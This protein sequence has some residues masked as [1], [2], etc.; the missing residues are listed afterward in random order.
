MPRHGR[1]VLAATILG[2]SLAFIDG[3]AVNVALP[4]LQAELNAGVSELQWFVE[5]YMLLLAAMLL[6]GGALG[7]RFGRRRVFAVGVGIFALASLAC[8]AAPTSAWLIG[9]RAVQGVGAALLVPGSLAIISAAFDGDSRGKAIG[10]W[11]G[12]TA[13]MTAFGQVLGGWLVDHLSWRAIFYLNLP[14]AVVTLALLWRVP[15]SRDPTADHPLDW[16]GA[17]LATLGLGGVVFALIEAPG[18][19]AD[20]WVLASGLG[21]IA[22]LV[23]YWRI[24]ARSAHPMMPPSLFRSPTFVGANGLTLL[25]YAALGGALFF[26]PYNLIQVQGYSATT[27]GAA[28]LPFILEMFLLSRWAGGLIARYGARP[29][30]VVGPA[31]AALGF[32][33]L[34]LPGV[35]GPY[36]ST[37]LPGIAVLGLGMSVAVAPL[38]TAVMGAVSQEKAGVASGINNAVSRV[39]GLLAV[40][41]FGVVILLAFSRGLESRLSALDLP[42]ATQTALMAN[43]EQLAEL[44]PPAELAPATRAAVARAVDD[45]FVDGFRLAMALAAALALASAGVAWRWIGAEDRQ[46][47]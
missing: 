40:A 41:V 30:L 42:P 44:P 8:G 3:T 27:A 29:P 32:A 33:L 22:A 9:A 16:T 18:R 36:W 15:E 21:G 46:P 31:I 14:L 25:L 6:V 2:S 39:G 7:D 45:A 28:M 13:I 5:S 43:R 23:A 10:T 34:A 38:T 35:G 12:V 37:F 17:A 24:E 11:S 1:W 26:V 19:G 47:G 20:A 4:A